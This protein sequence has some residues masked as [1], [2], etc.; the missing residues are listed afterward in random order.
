M[1]NYIWGFLIIISVICSIITG[2]SSGISS[3]L[4]NGAEK[5]TKLLIT[6]FGVIVF[7]SG[8]MKVAEKSGLTNKLVKVL[9]PILKRI[10]PDVP[11]N[12][13]A[14]QSICMNI[15][16]NLMGVGNAATPFGLKAM[17]E[18]QKNN[19]KKD[20]ATDSMVIFVVMNTASIQLI[21]AT[22][23]YLRQSY[24][25]KAPFS[26]IPSVIF[27]SFISLVIALIIGKVLNKVKRWK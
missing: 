24:G 11:E 19:L 9:S 5:A 7:W 22:I 10:F 26:I 21:P 13:Q 3:G 25:S 15:S 27:C 18:L 12:S 16:A 23:G 6:L 2:N 1:I 20:T 8:I 14:F 4:M 17:S